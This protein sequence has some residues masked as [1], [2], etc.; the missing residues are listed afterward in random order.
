MWSMYK[1]EREAYLTVS[2]RL[3][4]A[5]I[6]TLQYVWA[7]MATTEMQPHNVVEKSKIEEN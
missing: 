4:S 6:T 3:A 1:Y 5:Q 2:D 7:V